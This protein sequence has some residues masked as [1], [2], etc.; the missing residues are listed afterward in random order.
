MDKIWRN[1]W[2]LL[3]VRQ[4]KSTLNLS[5]KGNHSLNIHHFFLGGRRGNISLEHVLRF[6]TGSD[7]EPL[8]EFMLNPSIKF[9]DIAVSKLF[10]PTSN[11]CI[12]EMRRPRGNTVSQLPNEQTLF[13]LCVIAF[14][15]SY[16][17]QIWKYVY[18]VYEKYVYYTYK[19][20]ILFPL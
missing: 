10:L 8:L 5:N 7:R 15:N 4:I 18:Y 20:Y 19:I 12:N 9:V 1:W 17:G 3:K 2:V 6:A 16:F 11:I 13:S 14:A